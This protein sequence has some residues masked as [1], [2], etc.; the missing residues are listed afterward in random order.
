MIKV[1]EAMHRIV[2]KQYGSAWVSKDAIYTLQQQTA[3]QYFRPCNKIW[4]FPLFNQFFFRFLL[5]SLNI[6][7]DPPL[8]KSVH[9]T[10]ATKKPSHPTDA[11]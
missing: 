2:D 1:C 3:Q 7:C 4:L 5:L 10:M 8:K 11:K 9:L 6:H